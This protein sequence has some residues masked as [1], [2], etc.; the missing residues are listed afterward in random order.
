MPARVAVCVVCAA[1][2]V[3]VR[4]A[5]R[6]PAAEGV[7]LIG[8]LQFAPAARL[9]P[10]VELPTGNSFASVPETVIPLIVS[11]A[12]PVFVRV[13]GCGA[14]VVPTTCGVA[15]ASDV[16]MSPTAGAAAALPVPVNV[17]VCGV[18]GALSATE[19]IA[20]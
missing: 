9:L 6:F 10:Q 13:I 8:I 16:G 1:L 11:V 14:L 5:V 19:T 17:T 20:V 12:L 2:S 15:N 18:D 4:V 3:I 7:K